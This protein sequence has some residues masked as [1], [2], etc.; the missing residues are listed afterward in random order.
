MFTEKLARLAKAK[1]ELKQMEAKMVADRTAALARLPSEFGFESLQD[2]IAALKKAGM[3]KGQ[4]PAGRSSG[5]KPAKISKAPGKR[6]RIT[7]EIKAQVKALTV[8]GKTG[9]EIAGSLGISQAS[10]QNIRKTLGLV[11]TRG[12]AASANTQT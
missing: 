12:E 6:A 1:A 5:A 7:D 3:S 8:A 9:Q 10:V 4:R 2:F 11:K